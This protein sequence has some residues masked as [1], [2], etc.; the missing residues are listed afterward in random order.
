MMFS[1]IYALCYKC[2]LLVSVVAANR[3]NA[4]GSQQTGDAL[5]KAL[6]SVSTAHP[7]SPPGKWESLKRDLD[8]NHV[9]NPQRLLGVS[10]IGLLVNGGTI[11][12]ALKIAL[13]PSECQFDWGVRLTWMVRNPRWISPLGWSPLW[14]WILCSW[15]QYLLHSL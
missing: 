2:P 12:A 14:V 5:G 8:R 9:T 13:S 6:A 7:C 10:P 11:H 1:L 3:G 4:S 15:L